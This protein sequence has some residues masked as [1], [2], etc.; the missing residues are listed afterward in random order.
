MAN[1]TYLQDKGL[2]LG[3]REFDFSVP[4]SFETIVNC[5]N[6]I[7]EVQENKHSALSAAQSGYIQEIFRAIDCQTEKQ[8]LR[9]L[10]LSNMGS[11][12]YPKAV[13]VTISLDETFDEMVRGLDWSKYLFFAAQFHH[14]RWGVLTKGLEMRIYDF[15]HEDYQKVYFS[16][17]LSG[18]A[19]E[20]R[21]E[22]LFT[23]Y[24]IFS[25]IRGDKENVLSKRDRTLVAPRQIIQ[26]STERQVSVSS[27][28]DLAYHTSN[29]SQSSLDLFTALQKKILALPDSIN[30]RYNKLY[31]GYSCNKKNFCE[32]NIQ[33]KDLKVWVD[34]SIGEM[35]NSLLIWRD[36]SKIGRAS[37]GVSEIV[38]KNIH[39]VD[40]VF[41]IIKQSYEKNK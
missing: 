32:I 25:Y 35:S 3:K 31:I 24:K 22:D 34:L 29:K 27:E 7:K 23:V 10:T 2:F 12:N 21:L 11:D 1:N 41:K 30:E 38:L 6:T 14:V 17:D 39:D 37:S 8:D 15:Q 19:K 40:A 9:L 20:S 36:V 16:A 28:Y 18:V 26:R 13:I 5:M 4:V 33:K